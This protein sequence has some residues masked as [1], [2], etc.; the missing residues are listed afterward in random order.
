MD[1]LLVVKSWYFFYFGSLVCVA[2]YLNI[3]LQDR[4]LNA[5]QIG[6]IA[7]SRPWISAPASFI[8]SGLA[9]AFKL[10]RIIFTM[11][12]ILS[13]VATVGLATA[14]TFS[15]LLAITTFAQLLAA[16]V[17][18]LA[19][20][21]AVACCKKD[22]DYGKCRLWGAVSWG[23][24]STFTGW[25]VSAYGINSG[26]AAYTLLALPAIVLGYFFQ[27]GPQWEYAKLAAEDDP[28]VDPEAAALLTKNESSLP[29]SDEPRSRGSSP[30][31]DVELANSLTPEFAEHCHYD[32]TGKAPSPGPGK[33]RPSGLQGVLTLAQ[34]GSRSN[35]PARLRAGSRPS[36][37]PSSPSA[38]P[39]RIVA[40][41]ALSGGADQGCDAGRESRSLSGECDLDCNPKGETR[42]LDAAEERAALLW[43][44]EDGS[45]GG[46]LAGLEPAGTGAGPGA[47]GMD[48]ELTFSI[49]LRVLLSRP[50]VWVF[51]AQA[52]VMGVGIGVIGEFLFLL[53]REMGGSE[54]LMGLTLTFT[55]ASEVPAFAIQ[56]RLLSFMGGVGP[57]L[58][59]VLLTYVL[60]L[61]AYAALPLAGTPWAVLPIELLHGITFAM[62]WGCGTICAKRVAPPGLEATM[63]GIF[64]GLYFGVGQGLGALV[65][66]LAMQ[67]YGLQRMFAGSAL[68][69]A[70]GWAGIAIAQ[71]AIAKASSTV[72]VART[73]DA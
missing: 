2:P 67:H 30:G 66:G 27:H 9:D 61:G 26:F 4:G 62:G 18:V 40:V 10:H 55:C 68:A 31:S 42:A 45:I 37:P 65:G 23:G 52:T 49:K 33:E 71:A 48:P 35:S 11:A 47:S 13:T 8:W 32:A 63:Q 59:L 28:P 60:R 24:L 6:V 43:A 19:D 21:A 20:A 51:M 50:A 34:G 70:A 12:I 38:T 56:D 29:H 16:P 36:Q 64:T 58:H 69:V 57:A 44:A 1:K 5:W 25:M 73:S 3:Y 7:A 17:V 22:T 54:M 72:K 14:S 15:S 53:L 46:R 41:A 39:A